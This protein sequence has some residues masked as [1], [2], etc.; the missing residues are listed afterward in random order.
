MSS[1]C[2]LILLSFFA[3]TE[4]PIEL[5]CC[6]RLLIFLCTLSRVSSAYILDLRVKRRVKVPS[7]ASPLLV[8][9]VFCCPVDG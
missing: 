6:S 8:D 9:H 4:R 5:A 2:L 3:L 7:D 1:C